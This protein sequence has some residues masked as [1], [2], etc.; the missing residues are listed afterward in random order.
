MMHARAAEFALTTPCQGHIDFLVAAG[1]ATHDMIWPEPILAARGH[2]HEDGRFDFDPEGEE[3]LAIAEPEDTVFWNPETGELAL[4][5]GR[6]F[7]LGEAVIW[8]PG[9]FALGFHLNIFDNPL[10]WLVHRRDGIVPVPTQWHLAFERL[11]DSPR[12]AVVP[13]LLEAYQAAMRP[14]VPDVAVL[15]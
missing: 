4:A 11:R 7:A 2:R 3:W 9:M 15:V 10:D 5:T 13:S 14:R 6:A 1:I 12:V 8:E